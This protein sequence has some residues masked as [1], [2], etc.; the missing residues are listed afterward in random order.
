M[1]RQTTDPTFAGDAAGASKKART[2]ARLMAR[3]ASARAAVR[4]GA[5]LKSELG[6]SDQIVAQQ[7]SDYVASVAREKSVLMG[8]N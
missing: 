7:V 6:L 5:I 8:A 2:R 1:A 4:V 3:D